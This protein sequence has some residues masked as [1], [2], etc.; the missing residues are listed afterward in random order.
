MTSSS[1]YPIILSLP[2]VSPEPSELSSAPD[3]AP[4][5]LKDGLA[6]ETP[7]TSSGSF[8]PEKGT[9]NSILCAEDSHII[10]ITMSSVLS[11]MM[12]ISS[13]S[14]VLVPLNSVEGHPDPG[15]LL[16]PVPIPPDGMTLITS[17]AGHPGAT[18]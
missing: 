13:P 11:L 16:I 14:T 1:S 6:A 2:L 4:N 15:R 12:G 9:S 3:P 10:V 7:F 18:H 5:S 17:G 8:A